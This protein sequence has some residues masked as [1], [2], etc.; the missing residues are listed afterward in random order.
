MT[1]KINYAWFVFLCVL[2]TALSI[3]TPDLC[4]ATTLGITYPPA[5]GDFG[6]EFYD[7]AV[8]GMLNG[9]IGF[10]AGIVAIVIGAAAAIQQRVL[11]AVPSILGGVALINAENMMNSLAATL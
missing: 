6:Y 8:N 3:V 7:I 9:P 5:A 2:V 1:S 4:L 10:V 11:L